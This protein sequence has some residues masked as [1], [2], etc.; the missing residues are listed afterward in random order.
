MAAP[1]GKEFEQKVIDHEVRMSKAREVGQVY[2]DGRD[3][4]TAGRSTQADRR[5]Y[6]AELVGM[7][8]EARSEADLRGL[9]F[10]D[11]VVREARLGDTLLDAWARFRLPHHASA[12]AE[13][14]PDA[15]SPERSRA[16]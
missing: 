16:S 3:S 8:R 4:R 10:S 11:D 12:P 7:L 14:V 9:G 13:W 5:W 1:H 2:S 15:P 6:R